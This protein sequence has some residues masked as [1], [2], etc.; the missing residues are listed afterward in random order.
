MT[1]SELQIRIVVLSPPSGVTFAVQRGKFELLP[2]RREADSLVFEFTVRVGR[3]PDGSPNF[4]GPYTQGPP[5]VR[6]VYVNSG[7]SAGQQKTPW[8][9][10]AKVPL[11]AITWE[12]IELARRGQG[13]GLEVQFPGIGRDGGPT[14]A[15]VKLP[16]GAWRVVNDFG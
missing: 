2:P 3:Q 13:T 6:F 15:S 9:R 5:S 10:R 7:T 12:Q 16:A 1:E 4:L 8:T 14:C 11:M